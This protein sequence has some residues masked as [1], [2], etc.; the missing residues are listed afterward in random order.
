MTTMRT[1][2]KSMCAAALAAA[3]LL[4]PAPARTCGHEADEVQVDRAMA[5]QT[6]QW[7]APARSATA[8]TVSLQLL[9]IND[10]HGQLSGKT[11]G[12]R[13]AGGAAV[14]LSYLQAETRAF[15]GTTIVVHA[16]DH[17]G[18]SP[19][20]SALLQ[21]EP[22]IAVLNLLANDA[23]ALEFRVPQF[24]GRNLH[25]HPDCNVVG[26]FGNHE[27]DEGFAEAK[28][29]IY[30]G[31][32]AN[33]PF[34]DDPWRGANYPYVLANVVDEKTGA[35]VLPPYV[36]KNVGGIPVAFIGAVLKETPTIVTPTGVAGLAFLDEAETINA[37]VHQLQGKGVHAFV[38]TIH[39]GGS[40]TS[41][42][43]PTKPNGVVTGQIKD[44][45]AHLDADVDVVV[46]GHTHSFTNALL[47]GTGDVPV[48]V[49]QAFSAST[50]YDDIELT[51]D[52]ATGDV[53]AKSAS[54]RTT[55]GDE[56][57]GLTP[58]PRAAALVAA[59]D[60]K[61]APLVN[62]VVG[63]SAAAITRVESA[64]GESAMGNLIA[65]AQ[66]AA[67]GTE[68]AFMNPG[69]IR[70]DLDAGQVTWGELFTIQPF[71]NSL[72][73]MTLTGDQ[74]YRVLEQQWKGQPFP[75]VMKTSGFE[76]TWDPAAPLGARVVEVRKNGVAIDRSATYSVTCNNFMAAGGDNFTVFKEGK[77]QVGGPIDLDALVTYVQ[78]LAQPFGAAIEGRIR[79]R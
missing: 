26:T 32:H 44:I 9:G 42:N 31:N 46:S 14:L 73:T 62:R 35:N 76:Y 57:P 43:G 79:T 15:D 8:G 64:A 39:Q 38:V 1:V 59:A 6:V 55:W 2:A 50:A 23:C 49:A 12:P 33:G 67:T 61:V 58:D 45:V 16:G 41:Y 20:N 75:R 29:L 52:R 65:D 22:A 48:L 54:V 5:A 53:I 34:L 13:P 7:S 69:G 3:G 10:F 56:G 60:V 78:S 21:D 71:G 72:V 66:R 77:N 63:T 37:I 18:A 47:P 68:F 17:V 74:I 25:L 51:L 27:F 24:P 70:A 30:G 28:R 19:P 40:Q 4:Y 11:V 36:I